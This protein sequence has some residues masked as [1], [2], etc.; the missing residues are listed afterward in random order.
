MAVTFTKTT[1][2]QA[3]PFDGTSETLIA[4]DGVLVDGALV[5]ESYMFPSGTADAT[6][7]AKVEA[8]LAA[9][10][11][12]VTDPTTPDLV[13]AKKLRSLQFKLRVTAYVAKHYDP[14]QQASLQS[15]WT[16]GVSK[17]WPNRVALV[18]SVMDWVNAVLGH[19]YAKIDEAIAAATIPD[20][21][22]V[23]LDLAQFD[24]ADP[25]VSV[26]TVKAT[27]D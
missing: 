12:A 26:K 25:L 4:V 5:H 17:G 20:V 6:I 2:T 19:F 3:N 23:D 10:G 13:S 8:D 11:Y 27:V 22:A 24:A 14:G 21:Q 15:L 9:K 18:Q 7:Q 16:E 1:K